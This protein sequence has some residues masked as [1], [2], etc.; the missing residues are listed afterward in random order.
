VARRRER[1]VLFRMENLVW[2]GAGSRGGS[3][4]T[5]VGYLVL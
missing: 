5:L 1:L 2:V 3:V 4:V